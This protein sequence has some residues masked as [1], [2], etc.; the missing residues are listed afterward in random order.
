MGQPVPTGAPRPPLMA[1]VLRPLPAQSAGPSGSRPVK[2]CPPLMPLSSSKSSLVTALVS[3]LHLP[4]A[5][6]NAFLRLGRERNEA[7]LPRAFLWGLGVPPVNYGS[8]TPPL[9]LAAR[10]R[11]RC[12][13]GQKLFE[14]LRVSRPPGAFF[15]LFFSCRRGHSHCACGASITRVHPKDPEQRVDDRGGLGSHFP[16][17][18]IWLVHRGFWAKSEV[19]SSI[20]LALRKF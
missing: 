6:A 5:A 8:C 16:L 19:P 13:A 1:L 14:T 12:P 17:N 9:N 10:G 15:S 3:M 4:L 7:S 20:F 2:G 18:L 11:F